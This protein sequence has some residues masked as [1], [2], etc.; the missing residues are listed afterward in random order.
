MQ[1]IDSIHDTAGWRALVGRVESLCLKSAVS[2]PLRR[3]RPQAPVL[4][5]LWLFKLSNTVLFGDS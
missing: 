3:A 2:W 4:V 5:R 1:G